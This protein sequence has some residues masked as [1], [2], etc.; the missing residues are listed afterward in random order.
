MNATEIRKARG[1]L[2]D[3]TNALDLEIADLFASD[4]DGDDLKL[5]IREKSETRKALAIVD[6][7]AAE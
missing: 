4:P 6:T 2:L 1:M 7:M 3:R 5:A